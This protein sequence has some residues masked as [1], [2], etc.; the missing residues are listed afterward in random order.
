MSSVATCA[1]LTAMLRGTQVS[2]F[3]PCGAAFPVRAHLCPACYGSRQHSRACFAGQREAVLARDQRTCQGCWATLAH[4]HVHHRRP[5]IHDRDHLVTLCAACHARLHKLRAI[6]RWLPVR[7]VP[8]W[9][10]QHPGVP[11]QLQ[12]GFDDQAL[13]RGA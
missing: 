9:L 12:F 11:E 7:L 2:L 4:P 5:G 1:T 3:C 8:L 13:G 6:R 10:E